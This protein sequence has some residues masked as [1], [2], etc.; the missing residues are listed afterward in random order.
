MSEFDRTEQ[1]I[2][3]SLLWPVIENSWAGTK[4]IHPKET[5]TNNVKLL[6]PLCPLYEPG[7]LNSSILIPEPATI[8]SSRVSNKWNAI[9][10]I[11]SQLHNSVT[12]QGGNLEILAVFANKG[13]LLGHD[14]VLK[15]EYL[16]QYHS[17]LYA[18]VLERFL[19]PMG[20]KF[21]YYDYDTLNVQFPRFVNPLVD[22]G[23]IDPSIMIAQLNQFSQNLGIPNVVNNKKDNRHIINELIKSFGASDTF[24]LV[25]GYLAFDYMIPGLIGPEGLYLSTER[26]AGLFRIA[27]LTESLKPITKIEVPA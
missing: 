16:L 7:P 17:A 3:G 2:N 8:E 15:D 13:V 21:T 9:K 5:I 23:N 14:P 6:F 24:W 12:D 4:V 1:K 19:T 22:A 10:T 20:I 11:V 26:F 18:N 27:K 25:S